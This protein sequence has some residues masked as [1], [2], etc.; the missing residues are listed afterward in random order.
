MITKPAL[1]VWG[2]ICGD[3]IGS[4]Y[5][6]H[7]TKKYNFRLFTPFSRFTDDTVCTIAVADAVLHSEP[8][9]DML[10]QWCRR[11]VRAGYGGLFR[12][13]IGM[14]DP[15]PYNSYGNGS[16]MRVSACGAL[17]TSLDEALELARES[18][19]VTHN[20]P[21]GIKGAQ[22]T[23][24]AIYMGL[25]QNEL[26]IT[27][28]SDIKLRLEQLFGYNLSR[29]YQ[30]IKASYKFEVS[31]QASVPEAIIA[32][33]ASDDYESTIRHAVS[34]GGDADTQAAIAGSIA[35]AYYGEI[36]MRILSNV[37]DML[38]DDILD[39]LDE[40]NADTLH[41]CQISIAEILRQHIVGRAA[42]RCRLLSEAKH[43]FDCRTAER[44]VPSL[45]HIA[46][47][48]LTV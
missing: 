2:A 23:A 38:P 10:Q 29:D 7:P 47:Q 39:I 40:L 32:F 18:A 42:Y 44:T 13:W 15:R 41:V 33:L 4:A 26:S 27:S 28:K 48:L 43:A 45:L 37:C 22:A 12:R 6:F 14:T 31:C 25:H 5:E 21:E 1:A 19:E 9:D 20:H 8:F 34:L 11:Y 36:P 30:E 46:C 35:A 3:V 17:A 24:A 16:A